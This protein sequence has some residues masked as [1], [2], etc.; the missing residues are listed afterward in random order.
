MSQLPKIYSLSC[1]H[2]TKYYW[3]NVV[4]EVTQGMN[5]EEKIKF[6]QLTFA[7]YSGTTE[8]DCHGSTLALN[9][10]SENLVKIL[11][12]IS[13]STFIKY[14]IDTQT[15][16]KTKNNYYL[17][18]P[19]SAI[20]KVQN[21]DIFSRPDLDKY[22]SVNYVDKNRLLVLSDNIYYIYADFEKWNG[23]NI[24]TV[25]DTTHFFITD[26]MKSQLDR[27]SL[28]NVQTKEIPF[29]A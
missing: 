3:L 18:K 16:L 4:E 20:P 11:E 9:F 28:K 13:P 15:K 21:Q 12:E 25:T 26:K 19:I 22:C 29:F 17:V 1:G 5:F 14:K 8:A 7:K 24:F 10:F 27:H 6:T 23:D 2:A